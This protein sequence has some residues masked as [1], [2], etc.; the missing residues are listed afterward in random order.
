MV[1][2]LLLGLCRVARRKELEELGEESHWVFTSPS[3]YIPLSPSASDALKDQWQHTVRSNTTPLAKL[4]NKQCFQKN[5]F[6][7]RSQVK[8]IRLD[9]NHITGL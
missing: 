9:L 8:N 3:V 6:L 7:Y 1:D 5:A 4:V 2:W